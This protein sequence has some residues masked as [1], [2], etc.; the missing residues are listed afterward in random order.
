MKL[1]N[2]QKEEIDF[3]TKVIKNFEPTEK[4]IED[5]ILGTVLGKKRMGQNCDNRIFQAKRT[6]DIAIKSW[7]DDIKKGN[8]TK[9]ELLE[10]FDC[11]YFRKI[12]NKL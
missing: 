7:R 1:T 5:Y 9:H 11:A 2:K 4:E 6:L 8:L 12:L 3:L 10:D